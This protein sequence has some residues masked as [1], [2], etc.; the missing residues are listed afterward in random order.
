MLEIQYSE[1]AVSQ[2]KAIAGSN[3]QNA[4]LI[5]KKIEQFARSP[6]EFSDVKVLKGKHAKFKRLR[7]GDFRIIFDT[8]NRIMNIYQ[9]KHRKEAYR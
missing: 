7:A 8:E 3:K 2:L 6:E 9:I 4:V 5:L 1:T